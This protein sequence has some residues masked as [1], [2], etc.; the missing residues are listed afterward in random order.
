MSLQKTTYN[1]Q[2][3]LLSNEGTGF[4]EMLVTWQIGG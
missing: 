4:T 1:R 2:L 3:V